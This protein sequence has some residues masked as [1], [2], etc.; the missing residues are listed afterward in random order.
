MIKTGVTAI[1][2]MF[3][4]VVNAT[5]IDSLEITGGSFDM[6][7]AGGVLSPGAFANMTIG[8]YDGSSPGA[9]AAD[10]TSYADSSIA[11]FTFG[12]FGPVAIY[13]AEADGV[14]SGFAPVSGDI[15]GGNLT[16]DLSSWTIFWGG[17]S[18]N[19]GGSS[20]MAAGS[21]CVNGNC[22]SAITTSYDE[23]TGS[24]TASWDAVIIGGTFNGQLGSWCIEGVVTA[25][26]VPIPA[27]VWLFGSG[28]VGLS[29]IACRRKAV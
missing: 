3:C 13:T 15:A 16:L 6:S 25:S 11:T 27:A 18:L 22:S 24:F 2:L 20:D 26:E 12:Y 28:L 19:Q 4:G 17:Y 8:G 9:A 10:E 21:V 7:G 29:G 14:N 1:F 5:V 23:M